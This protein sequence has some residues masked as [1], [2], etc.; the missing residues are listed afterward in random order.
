MNAAVSQAIA[1]L[2]QSLSV[3]QSSM[4]ANSL[5]RPNAVIRTL[6][7]SSSLEDAQ[8]AWSRFLNLP[9]RVGTPTVGAGSGIDESDNVGGGLGKRG[10]VSMEGQAVGGKVKSHKDLWGRE[11][12]RPRYD[13]LVRG[14]KRR[15]K[16]G[17][18][19]GVVRPFVA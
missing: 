11:E 12:L 3:L 1:G 13:A 9:G 2:Q 17:R 4:L 8:Q 10:L 18:G 5:I 16:V 15:A 14:E 19:D 7:A 6:R